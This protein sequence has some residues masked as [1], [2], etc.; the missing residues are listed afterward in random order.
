MHASAVRRAL[1]AAGLSTLAAGLARAQR[2][3]PLPRVAVVFNAI[4]VSEMQGADPVDPI[5]RALVHG[6][7]DVGLVDGR[8]IVIE[9]RSAEE[10]PERMPALMRELVAQRVAVIVAFGPAL[11][12]AREATRSIPIVGVAGG[13]PVRAGLAATYARP[14]GNLTVITEEV[15][16]VSKGL[17]LLKEIAPRVTRVAVLAP[18]T[19]AGH[20]PPPWR[21]DLEATARSLNMDLQWVHV[22]RHE[23]FKPALELILARRSDAIVDPGTAITYRHQRE[24]M[25]FAASARLPAVG[26]PEL[27]GLLQYGASSEDTCRR[28]AAYVAKILKGTKP[29]EL[30]VEAIT[31]YELV[32]NRRT[33]AALGLTVPQSVVLRADRVID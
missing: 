14:G 33:A 15:S 3:R 16:T 5:A 19:P 20:G 26:D 1:L 23:D 8:D 13:D 18:A 11:R 27:G 12:V 21:T 31:K 32:V 9:R 29:G 22:D 10:H 25:A 2:K 30:P 28:A 17:E 6:L 24:L 4:P 7:R